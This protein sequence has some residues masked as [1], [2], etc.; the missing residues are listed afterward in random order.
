MSTREYTIRR[1]CEQTYLRVYHRLPAL[2]L[3]IP[4][5]VSTKLHNA[6][7]R[8]QRILIGQPEDMHDITNYVYYIPSGRGRRGRYIINAYATAIYNLTTTEKYWVCVDKLIPFKPMYRYEYY[9]SIYA[10]EGTSM[11][12][13]IFNVS[14]YSPI[15]L[16]INE[17]E[18]NAREAVKDALKGYW[19]ELLGF[20]STPAT[21]K[22]LGVERVNYVEFEFKDTTETDI[23]YIIVDLQHHYR[24]YTWCNFTTRTYQGLMSYKTSMI[25]VDYDNKSLT[26]IET[27]LGNFILEN[28]DLPI[29]QIR[30]YQTN[31]GYHVYIFLKN[32]IKT[33]K[34]M[35][36]RAKLGDDSN[37]LALDEYKLSLNYCSHPA[38]NTLFIKKWK[39]DKGIYE[40]ASH[41]TLI[42]II[43]F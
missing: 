43:N 23:P 42:K 10:P 20:E 5:D 33:K 12:D 41:E 16:T 32:I 29:K 36:L 24:P 26:E 6:R 35:D 19:D 17:I 38:F 25:T 14:F 31:H 9:F 40:L 7:G 27:I 11:Q 22:Y 18:E 3:Y 4:F 28:P 21:P 15:E 39:Y 30:I 8:T 37:R 1:Y 13:R 34:I 2:R